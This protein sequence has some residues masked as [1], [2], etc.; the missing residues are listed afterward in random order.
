MLKT[1]F[2][3]WA[4]R[5]GHLGSAPKAAA[6]LAEEYRDLEHRYDQV[7][8]EIRSRSPRYAALTRPRSLG[9]RS[10]QKHVLDPD[11]LLL[12]YA[13]GEERS[14]VWAV[15]TAGYT[16]AVLPPRARIEGQA[17]TVHERLTSR[18]R[19]TGS[20]GERRRAIEEA[21]EAYW[22]E[23]ADLSAML[24]GPVAGRLAG[25][26][27]L[28]VADGV[29][30]YV[31][32][33][34]LPDPGAATSGA[35]LAVGHEVVGLPSAS[36]LAVLR[37][38]APGRPRSRGAIAILADPVFE[39]DDPRLPAAVG[40]GAAARA[41]A[42][43][44]EFPRLAATRQEA[45][46]IVATAPEGT[47]LLATGFR[48]SRATATSHELGRYRIVHFAT[49]GV[50]DDDHPERSGIVL[51]MFDERGQPRDGFLRLHDVYE[52]DLP[53]DLVV[54]SAC[55]TA[56]GRPVR[57]EGLVGMVRGFMHAGAKRVVASL[58]KVDDEATGELMRSF[59]RGMLR[60]GRSPAAALRQAQIDL[61][62]SRRW[63]APFYWAA[64]VLQGE[65][66]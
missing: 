10:I 55:D 5:Q 56:L 25:K 49:H 12:E 45:A 27:L 15:S 29:L 51:S 62:N 18:L 19:A 1:A 14:Y 31:P 60:E 47:T 34:A 66:H 42:G 57:G 40:R 65:P 54:L 3:D 38:E 58:W 9:L 41:P 36:V 48:A 52:L 37:A 24:L 28:V 2:G 20:P 30:Q 64:F 39:H 7:Q 32:F 63:H 6:A 17:K 26:R 59:Y 22:K 23:A 8:A 13:L 11:T 50:F 46:G 4:E 43:A 53:V 33:A 35:P 16:S 44:H 21:D 61:W